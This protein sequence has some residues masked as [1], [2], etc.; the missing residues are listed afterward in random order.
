MQA[1]HPTIISVIVV[2][3]NSTKH[4][5]ICLD[6]LSQ[7]TFRD[8]EVILIDN[9]SL[10]G[11]TNELEQKYPELDLH[12]ER[13]P[14]NLGFA[15]ANN[16]GAHLAHGKWLALLNADA[17]PE[18]EWLEKLLQAAEDNPD[19]TSF[20]SAK[21]KPITRNSWTALGMLTTSVVW[22][23]VLALVILQ[24]N[25]GSILKN[26]LVPVP[27]QPC[28]CAKRFWRLEVSTK[29]SSATLKM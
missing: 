6:C 7:Q 26:F 10:D 29:I 1:T 16:I 14:L 19:I 23:G 27:P 18:P 12:L 28:T 22:H 25:M 9:G 21:F 11:G 2:C 5:P 24:I 20:S 4:L 8:F 13:Q 3:W 15:A 17:F